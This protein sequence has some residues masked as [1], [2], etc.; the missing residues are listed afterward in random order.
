MIIEIRQ[1]C[2]QALISGIVF[3]GLSTTLL[4][5]LLLAANTVQDKIRLQLAT[6]NTLLSVL[7]VQA[8]GL[9]AISIG[10]RAILSNDALAASLNAKVSEVTFYRKVA[11]RFSKVI[12]FIPYAGPY[13]AAVLSRGGQA[14]ER[15]MDRTAAYIIPFTRTVNRLIRGQQEV[16][17]KTAPAVSI[18]AAR[19]V[20]NTC[21][22]G[23]RLSPLS[24]TI[25]ARQ[26]ADFSL[27]FDEME[28]STARNLLMATMDKQTRKRN[29][30]A[31]VGGTSL[32]IKKTGGTSL[33]D[34]DLS[35]YDK[36]KF[37]RLTWKGWRWKTVLSARSKASQYG[38]R[39]QSPLKTLSEDF[40]TPVL[41]ISATRQIQNLPAFKNNQQMMAISSAEL[42]YKNRN[43][44]EEKPNLL[45]PEWRS[46]LTPISN[47][48]TARRIV[49]KVILKEILH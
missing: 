32:P 13:L 39:G 25:L 28:D 6:D 37:R 16:I 43:I 22:P 48:P 15:L 21:S 33:T 27:G 5:G 14:I 42:F 23:S 46:R 3:L 45:N 1:Q 24:Y 29:W 40:S 41:T 35:A 19:Q 34:N 7:N 18:K 26:V 12:R 47:D 4:A 20:F 8:N 31:K 44:P 9:N 10:N 2:G 17:V 11:D 36:L 38:Y 30:R 49:P